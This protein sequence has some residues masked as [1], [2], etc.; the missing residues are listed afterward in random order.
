MTKISMTSRDAAA[1]GRRKK[2]DPE[3]A[4]RKNQRIA[5]DPRAEKIFG[6]FSATRLNL[7]CGF[8]YRDGYINVDLQDFHK[9]DV[10]ADILNL[11]EFPSGAFDEIMAQDV[12]EH[13]HWRDTPRALYEWNRVLAMDGRLFIRTTYL[14]GL[15]RKFESPHYQ[16]IPLQKLLLVNL[17]SM[18]N[19]PGDYHLTAFTE[20]LMRFYLWEAGYEIEAIEIQDEWLFRIEAKKAVDYSY[21]DLIVGKNDDSDFVGNLYQGALGRDA[22]PEG[23]ASYVRALANGA[24]TREE[25]V[26]ALLLSDERQERMTSSCPAFPLRFHEARITDAAP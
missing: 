10:V 22:D 8:D 16:T 26:K 19:Y 24:M 23:L 1:S 21:R 13:F 14:N 4:R 12:L 17:F 5:S 2:P 9:P 25:L 6:K 20:R 15:L 7:G 3:A 11:K 18:Q